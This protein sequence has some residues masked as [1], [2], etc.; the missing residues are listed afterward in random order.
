MANLVPLWRLPGPRSAPDANR[1]KVSGAVKAKM[2]SARRHVAPKVESHGAEII[3]ENEETVGISIQGWEIRT[4]QGSIADES[5][6]HHCTELCQEMSQCPNRNNVQRQRRLC[7]PEMVF[8]DAHITFKKENPEN[9]GTN[10]SPNS[11]KTNNF[12]HLI[13]DATSAL[14]EWAQAHQ[15]I[16][17]E[18][19][20]EH[21]GVSVLKSLDAE[22]WLSKQPLTSNASVF[23]YDWSF[24]TP[25]IGGGSPSS[26]RPSIPDNDV[27]AESL[28]MP[29][30]PA[31]VSSSK[32]GGEWQVKDWFK[33]VSRSSI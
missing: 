27:V 25:Y 12:F 5:S 23:H 8:M 11:R 21:R 22:Q 14:T 26:D 2:A 7:L 4:R 24:S 18:D 13:L 32:Y 30:S 31:S 9:N 16:G 17:L 28:P 10:T 15:E 1:S 33:V 6:L 3:A 20:G 19:P 29:P